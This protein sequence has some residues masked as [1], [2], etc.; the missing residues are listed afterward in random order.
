MTMPGKPV[1]RAGRAAVLVAF[2]LACRAEQ[3]ASSTQ[4]GGAA[5]TSAASASTPA[6]TPAAGSAKYGKPGDPVHLVV[7]YQPY[8]SEAWSGIVVNGLGLWKKH[9]PEGCKGR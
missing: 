3:S 1:S 4:A 5:P 8:Y 6:P 7:G 2:S 9:L